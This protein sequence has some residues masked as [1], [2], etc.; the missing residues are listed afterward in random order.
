MMIKARHVE[1]LFYAHVPQ[2]F[3]FWG[4]LIVCMEEVN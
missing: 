3:D 1:E 2:L 4:W